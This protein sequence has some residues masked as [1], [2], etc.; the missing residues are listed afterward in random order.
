MFTPIRLSLSPIP[1]VTIYTN[2]DGQVRMRCAT[3]LSH[4]QLSVIN[5]YLINEGFIEEDQS[6]VGA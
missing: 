5:K 6:L 4:Q 1:Q 3:K 2:E